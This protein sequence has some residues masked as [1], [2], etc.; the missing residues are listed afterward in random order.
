MNQLNKQILLI[1]DDLELIQGLECRI[2]R[3]FDFDCLLATDFR[4]AIQQLRTLP[5]LVICDVNLGVKNGLGICERLKYFT[6]QE[7]PFV[8]LTGCSDGDT[9]HRVVNL[10]AYYLAKS[11]G[12]WPKLVRVIRELLNLSSFDSPACAYSGAT[13]LSSSLQT[14]EY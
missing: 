1:D 7:T 14:Q 5:D 4:T 9:L 13:D 12:L 11:A 10:D 2:R 8:V 6:G 3:G